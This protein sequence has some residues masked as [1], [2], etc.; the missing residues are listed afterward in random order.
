MESTFMGI[1]RSIY[2]LLDTA[3]RYEM[4]EPQLTS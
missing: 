3:R 4:R 2:R 1:D